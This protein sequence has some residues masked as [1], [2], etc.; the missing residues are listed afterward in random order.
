[1]QTTQGCGVVMNNITVR[2]TVAQTRRPYKRSKPSVLID[3]L[4][5]ETGPGK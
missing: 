1:M 3:T 5:E 4:V 2:P